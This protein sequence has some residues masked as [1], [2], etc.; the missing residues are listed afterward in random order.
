MPEL[1]KLLLIEKRNFSNKRREKR[2]ERKNGV[3]ER[4]PRAHSLHWQQHLFLYFFFQRAQR[5]PVFPIDPRQVISSIV[6]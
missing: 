6:K 5:Y 4:A 2:K 3:Y 1:D